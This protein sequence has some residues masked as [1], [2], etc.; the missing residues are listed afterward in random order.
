M[1]KKISE[2]DLKITPPKGSAFAYETHPL[3][4][5]LHTVCLCVGK[6]GAGKTVAVTHLMSL[7]PF[8]RI[9]VVSP[10]MKSNRLVMEKLHIDPKDVEDD[11]DDVGVVTRII[12][13]IEAERV[14]L[15]KYEKDLDRYNEMIHGMRSANALFQ[16]DDNYGVE[17]FNTR[18][19][20]F[21]PPKHK[22]GGRKPCIAVLFDDCQSSFLFSRPRA[23]NNMVIKHRHLGQLSKGG[24]IGCSLFFLLQSYKTQS[25]G[26]TKTIRGQATLLM[27]FKTKNDHELD[28]IAEEVAGEVS[29]R[30]FMK[31]YNAAIRDEHDFL[32]IDLHRK[33]EHPS[34]FRRNLDTYLV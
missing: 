34:M 17:F 23:L 1:S 21:E 22:W 6:R 18:T 19:N 26:L 11:P 29:H 9:I 5:K 24:A 2:V 13:R 12:A 20:S 8:D 3:L 25:G 32:F 31:A 7:L 33:K 30:D 14:D 16:I 10:T 28:E 27:L 15:E 4:P